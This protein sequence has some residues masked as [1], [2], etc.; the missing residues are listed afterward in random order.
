MK[1]LISEIEP[2]EFFDSDNNQTI[3]GYRVAQVEQNSNIFPVAQGMFWID[4][5]DNVI[6]DLF[7]YDANTQKI[8]PVP[9][10]KF[11]VKPKP[12][13]DQPQ[14]SGTVTI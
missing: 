2:R 13:E 8:N 14:S 7:Y 10:Q 5:D 3:S 6:A 4:C 1:A 12:I 9:V 11:I